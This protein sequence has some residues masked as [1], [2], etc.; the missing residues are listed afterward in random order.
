LYNN[1]LN[2]SL[3]KQTDEQ[4][5]EMVLN[6]LKS[7]QQG[8]VDF[9]YDEVSVDRDSV[10]ID[11]LLKSDS[12][13]SVSTLVTRLECKDHDY[14]V[15]KNFLNDSLTAN[16]TLKNKIIILAMNYRRYFTINHPPEY[17][18]VNIPMAAAEYYRN[19]SLL[20]K[21]RT[22]VGRKTKP[23]PV[24]ASYITNIVTF[25]KWNVPYSIAVKEILPQ[26]QKNENYLEQKNYD[27]VDAKG[28][29][30][31]ESGLKWSDYNAKNFPYYF[32]QSTGEGNALGVLKFDLQNPFSIF[33][34]AT[35]WPENFK[36]E[37]R[38]LS[39]GCIQLEKPFEL[40]E[41]LLRGEI[42]IDELKSGK[43][44]TP[45]NT[46]TLIHKIPAFIIYMPVTVAGTKVTFLQ[47]V[48]G[49]IK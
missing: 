30:I 38:F 5:T 48:Y 40:A 15:L 42:N 2:D 24:F 1:N 18:I 25:P 4:I 23:T 11:Q 27:V 45:S 26:V 37:Y 44:N 13:K 47:D 20:I 3:K 43:R 8:N 9:K 16:D 14:I 17:I 22:V 41:A 34:H 28:K 7:M 10:Y 31:E 35:S 33:L 32:R 29:I 21:M 39:H 49:L 12:K 6:F 46:I 19:D 36:K